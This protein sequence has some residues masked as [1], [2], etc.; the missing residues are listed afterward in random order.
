[1]GLID[2]AERVAVD[3]LDRRVPGVRVYYGP[4]Y[5]AQ[6]DAAFRVVFVPNQDTYD[7]KH[8]M[9]GSNPRPIRTRHAGATV[10][11]WASDP[12]VPPGLGKQA[13]DWRALD[14]LINAFLLSLHMV[15]GPNNY[16][17]GTGNVNTRTPHSHYGFMYEIQIW[18]LHPITDTPWELVSPVD[19]DIHCH[20]IF[21]TGGT[22][23]ST[24]PAP[25]SEIAMGD[26]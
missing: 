23:S 4:E 8:S 17:L 10:Q 26:N 18:V 5:A 14:A 19:P 21:G 16:E 7:L 20:L 25:Q 6:D 11:L 22:V 9:N 12:S 3:L 2:V 1:M 15:S 24:I 13:A